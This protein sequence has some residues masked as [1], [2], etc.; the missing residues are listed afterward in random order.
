M[1][2][3]SL[4]YL[5]CWSKEI[6]I[7][8]CK[9][10]LRVWCNAK[11]SHIHWTKWEGPWL[12]FLWLLPYLPFKLS[13]TLKLNFKTRF[14]RFLIK[15]FS[16]W[17]RMN[18]TTTL[19]NYVGGWIV[20]TSFRFLVRATQ[21]S[22]NVSYLRTSTP[23]VNDTSS[24]LAITTLRRKRQLGRISEKAF[25]WFVSWTNKKRDSV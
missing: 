13:I 17:R 9:V 16:K 14:F 10:S 12:S 1:S 25:P 24:T 23:T 22:R 18:A 2:L 4:S 8:I 6:D 20:K 5:V 15:Y 3:F 11:I 7:K 19:C 21:A